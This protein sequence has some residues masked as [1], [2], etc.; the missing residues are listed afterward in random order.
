MNVNRS[1]FI[2]PRLGGLAERA[3]LH[4]RRKIFYDFM[5]ITKSQAD[6]K[7]LDIGV[8][9]D[10][11]SDSNFLEKFYPY[12]KNITAVGLEDAS[13]LEHRYPG[14]IFVKAD[15]CALPFEDQSFDIAFCSAVIEH[16]GDSSRQRKLIDEALRVATVALITTPNRWFPL[17]F[18]TLTPFLHWLPPSIFRGFLSLTGRKFFARQSNLN[19]L[20][21]RDLDCLCDKSGLKYKK[22]NKRL[23]GLVSNL[24]YLVY[25]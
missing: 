20:G 13:F 19:L 16:V 14:L 17:E 15:A 21:G 2:A 24:V 3:A 12:P 7:V 22:Y 23:L 4:I 9:S 5:N 1:R 18:H 6:L 8:T 25:R 10:E 11:S